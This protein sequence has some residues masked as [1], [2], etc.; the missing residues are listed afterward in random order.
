MRKEKRLSIHGRNEEKEQR[1]RKPQDFVGVQPNSQVI[2][3]N[4]DMGR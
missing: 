4:F 3:Q 1:L 2:G